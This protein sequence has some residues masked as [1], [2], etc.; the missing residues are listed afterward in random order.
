MNG[1]EGNAP[2]DEPGHPLGSFLGQNLDRFWVADARAGRKGILHMQ[3]WRVSRT[4]GSRY[5]T[6]GHTG[7]AVVYA[8]LGDYEHPTMLSGHQ[9]GVQASNAAADDY[10]VVVGGA[11]KPSCGKMAVLVC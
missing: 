6:L 1:V 5:T 9:C 11:Q 2:L 4:D 10:V 8:P 7:V 3:G